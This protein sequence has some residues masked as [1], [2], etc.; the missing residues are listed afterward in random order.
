MNVLIILFVFCSSV[1][2][3]LSWWCLWVYSVIQSLTWIHPYL[4]FLFCHYLRACWISYHTYCMLHFSVCPRTLYPKLYTWY[5]LWYSL[6]L[7]SFP[8]QTNLP[9]LRKELLIQT[10]RYAFFN[11]AIMSILT[12][13]LESHFSTL[14]GVILDPALLTISLFSSPVYLVS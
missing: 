3:F 9:T 11:M 12:M 13:Y 4:C 6:K 8:N 14:Y 7:G 2:C 1:I 10:K 5:F